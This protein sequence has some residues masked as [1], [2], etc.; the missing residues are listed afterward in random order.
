MICSDRKIMIIPH[1]SIKPTHCLPLSF[2]FRD[3]NFSFSTTIHIEEV[4]T[5][6]TSLETKSDER[7]HVGYIKQ[8]WS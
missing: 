6:N 1:E 5:L 2:F 8:I 7:L 4:V 3:S